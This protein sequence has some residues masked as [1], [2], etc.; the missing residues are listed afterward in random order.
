MMVPVLA[1]LRAAEGGPSSPFEVNFGLF[2]WTWI[3]FIPLLWLLYK[4]AFPAIVGATEARE[5]KIADQLAEAE[6]LNTEA[7]A[8]LAQHQQA[9]AEARSTAQALLA[10]ARAASEKERA[11]AVEK[12]Q[13]EQ[14]A[15]VDR[16]RR[17]I[18]AEREKAIAVLRQE[19]VELSLAA[20]SKLIG[21]RL[22]AAADRK[23]VEEYLATVSRDG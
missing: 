10:D 13:Q 7:K 19:A 2:V 18:A 6:R 3:V 12:A 5:K 9:A 21:Q 17:E 22:D 11:A 1:I 15:L 16:A 14:E 8:L 4:Y 20:A 23:L